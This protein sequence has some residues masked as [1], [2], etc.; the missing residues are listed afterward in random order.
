MSVYLGISNA[1]IKKNWNWYMQNFT[2]LESLLHSQNMTFSAH[3]CTYFCLCYTFWYMDIARWPYLFSDYHFIIYRIHSVLFLHN[4]RLYI[5]FYVSSSLQ[6]F[7]FPIIQGNDVLIHICA[8]KLFDFHIN[9]T[10]L[11]RNISPYKLEQAFFSRFI[12]VIITKTTEVFCYP[13]TMSF[14]WLIS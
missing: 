2:A 12:V 11:Y 4:G 8:S 5:E 14:C 13:V 3:S 9:L 10:T 1:V 6:S 7:L